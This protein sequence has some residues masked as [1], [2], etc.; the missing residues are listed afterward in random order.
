MSM[1]YNKYECQCGSCNR[2]QSRARAPKR[3]IP[4]HIREQ[5]AQ[6]RMAD[7][8]T[9]MLQ[10]FML[11]TCPS[12][13]QDRQVKGSTLKDGFSCDRCGVVTK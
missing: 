9:L 13:G 5:Y 3:R 1:N 4:Q 8:E 11:I 6:K 10:G 12:C 2:C 7:E